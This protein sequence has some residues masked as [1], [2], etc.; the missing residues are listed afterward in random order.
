M[1]KIKL[2]EPIAEKIRRSKKDFRVDTFTSKVHA[3]GS[4]KDTSNTAVRI[5]DLI[6][7]L[8][9]EGREERSQPQN[10][11]NAFYRLV[12]KMIDYYKTEWQ[13]ELMTKVEPSRAVRTYKQDKGYAVDHRT[14]KKYNCEELLSG[15]LDKVM[16]DL[17][18]Q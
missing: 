17:L 10:K 11:K 6:T 9:A 14:D 12:D 8:S 13:L 18:E 3:G 1:K 2:P 15:K 7:G 16:E 5:T 4:G